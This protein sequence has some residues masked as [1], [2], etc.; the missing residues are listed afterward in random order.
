[1]K[2]N[3]R[4]TNYA[5]IKI[6]FNFNLKNIA[7]LGYQRSEVLKLGDAVYCGYDVTC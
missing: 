3:K 5:I 6:N 2:K 4:L 7:M 1:M